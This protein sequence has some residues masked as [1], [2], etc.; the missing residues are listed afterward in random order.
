MID[1]NSGSNKVLEVVI[2]EI[3]NRVDDLERTVF[4]GDIK[5][6]LVVQIAELQQQL[7]SLSTKVDSKL[8]N[9][10]QNVKSQLKSLLETV[11]LKFAHINTTLSTY[12]DSIAAN[13]L[14]VQ[15]LIK[16]LDDNL[17]DHIKETAN[18][19]TQSDTNKTAIIVAVIACIGSILAS[20][21]SVI[22]I[23]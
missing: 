15:T 11:N 10:E 17:S 19:K 23:R 12:N 14:E 1:D 4:K 5:P 20:I 13:H 22:F 7:N 16:K 9:L 6:A 2:G 21:S 8:E 18:F 3:S